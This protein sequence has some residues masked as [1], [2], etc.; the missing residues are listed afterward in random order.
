MMTRLRDN[1]PYVPLSAYAVAATIMS[2]RDEGGWCGLSAKFLRE[3]GV[4]S[5]AIWPQGDR[6]GWKSHDRPETWENAAL[7]RVEEDWVDLT[8]QVYDQNLTFDQVASCL[9]VGIPCAVDFNWWGHSVCAL[10][11]VLVEKGSYGIRILNSWSDAWGDR[12]T[13][14]LQGRKAIPDGAVAIRTSRASAA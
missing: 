6:T 14:V 2:G 9:L 7:H 8:R 11:L 13:S 3:K 10:D 1:M 4:P 5:Q 12:G